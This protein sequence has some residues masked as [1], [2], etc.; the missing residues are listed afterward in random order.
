MNIGLTELVQEVV[1]KS[2]KLGADMS[3]VYCIRAKEL[4]IEVRHEQVENLKLAE[5]R[6]I[7]IRIF[8]KGRMGFAYTADLSPAA[9]KRALEEALANSLQA[10]ADEY[11]RLPEPASGY[12]QLAIFDPAIREETVENK[13]ELARRLEQAGFDFDSRV[14]ITEAAGYEDSEYEVAIAN[15]KGLQAE[16]RGSYAGLYLMLVAQEGEE[17]Q[18]GFSVQYS[19]RLAQ[20][21]PERVGREAAGKAVRM[22]GARRISTGRVPVVFDPYVAVNFLG[23]LAPALSAEAVQK[24]RSLFARR[25]GE[26]VGGNITIIDDGT[27]PEGIASAP[28]DGEGVPTERTVLLEGGV[29]KNFLYNTYTAARA[30]V[31]ST[32]NGM[33]GSFKATPEVGPT[34]LFIMPGEKSAP[35]LIGGVGEGLYITEVMGMH[36]ANPV[37]GDFSVGATGLWISGGEL[38][39]PVRG[40]TIAG[41][42]LELL[43]AVEG[44]AN[45]LT[46]FGG[47]GAPTLCIGRM[48]VGGE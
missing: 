46:F 43:E 18:T 13:I 25:L 45:D 38:A 3:E 14:K 34:N 10:S 35:D 32:G 29:L 1:K 37:S 9:V 47:R 48:T 39:Y 2:Q 4:S 17:S 23:V 31:K 20:L 42:L 33:R 40:I 44:V 21:E 27:L 5:E 19:R 28:F 22:L 16:Y 6:G 24:G 26:K 41:N 15:S 30:G 11:N 8:K 36:N 12:V 7:G